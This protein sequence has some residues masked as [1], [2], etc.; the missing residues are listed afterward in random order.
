[1]NDWIGLIHSVK[2]GSYDREKYETIS[3]NGNKVIQSN[4]TP[5][6]ANNP[7]ALGFPDNTQP[8]TASNQANDA[9]NQHN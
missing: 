3:K 7:S 5:T 6:F 9:L 2:D 4:N 8:I 1:M